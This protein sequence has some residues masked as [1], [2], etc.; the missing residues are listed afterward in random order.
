MPFNKN[1]CQDME[2]T[3]HIA[4][5]RCH[6]TSGTSGGGGADDDKS[7]EGRIYLAN[8]E[9][10]NDTVSTQTQLVSIFG[11]KQI[12]LVCYVSNVVEI[13]KRWQVKQPGW[14]V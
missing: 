10:T 3:A 14:S 4:E 2:Q 5:V 7:T 9:E 6:P 11:L 1:E 13:E 8:A 12:I